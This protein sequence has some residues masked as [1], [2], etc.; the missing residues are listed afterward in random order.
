MHPTTRLVVWFSLLIAGQALDGLFILAILLTLPAFG[1]D[2]VQHWQRLAWNTRWLILSLFAILSWGGLGEPAWPGPLAP[3]R[4]GLDSALLHVARLLLVLMAVAVL[5][6]WLPL[7]H[8]LRGI[9]GVLR[10]IRRCG[11]DTDRLLV[12]LVLVLQ[13]VD[14]L[15]P[16]LRDWRSL[17]EQGH[18]AGGEVI[19]LMDS[20]LS[21]IDY[22][23]I[24]LA[25]GLLAAF[26]WQRI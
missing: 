20:P 26:C 13:Q 18:G 16:S 2:V 12:R 19:E 15:A 11:V 14:T 23:S 8:L 9:H 7:P 21:G 1:R 3:T 22:L 25:T 5:R 24:S 17:L 10:P 6:R 4:E